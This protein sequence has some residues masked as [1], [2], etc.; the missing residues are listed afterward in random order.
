[1]GC[2]IRLRRRANILGKRLGE[3]GKRVVSNQQPNV[4]YFQYRMG[5][6]IFCYNQPMPPDIFHH[7][8]MREI[9]KP[10]RIHLVRNT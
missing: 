6:Q 4:S 1:M 7:T 5:K 8:H 10:L 3:S 2:S 9:V